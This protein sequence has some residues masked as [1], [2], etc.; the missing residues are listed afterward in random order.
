MKRGDI[1]TI[2]TG[3]PWDENECNHGVFVWITDKSLREVEAEYRQEHP[4]DEIEWLIEKGYIAQASQKKLHIDSFESWTQYHFSDD[5]P[6][7]IGNDESSEYE[8]TVYIVKRKGCADLAF[9]SEKEFRQWCEQEGLT[10]SSI[11]NFCAVTGAPPRYD[12]L[13]GPQTWRK[14][15]RKEFV[16]RELTC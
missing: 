13:A 15:T 11:N 12:E 1:F 4:C 3:W 2:E 10:Y 8:S 16:Y 14:G 7:N 9:Q 5:D 6:D